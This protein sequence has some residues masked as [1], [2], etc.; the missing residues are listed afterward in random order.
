M[1]K[2]I[3]YY[4]P[5]IPQTEYF[6]YEFCG[7]KLSPMAERLFYRW[8]NTDK[9]YTVDNK[10]AWK[11]FV[12][13]IMEIDSSINLIQNC[14]EFDKLCDKMKSDCERRKE[15]KKIYNKEHKEEIA[16]QK[17]LD[18]ETFGYAIINGEKVALG[19]YLVEEMSPLIVRGDDKRMF[20]FKY[21]TEP[22]DITINCVGDNECKKALKEKGFNVVSKKDVD[23]IVSYKIKLSGGFPPITK[24]I[25]PSATFSGQIKNTEHKHEKAL[26]LLKHFKDF[27]EKIKHDLNSKN[28]K[29]REIALATWLVKTYAI[30]I[31]NEREEFQADTVGVT[32]LKTK[33]VSVYEKNGKKFIHLSFLAKDSVPYSKV[34]EIPTD[35]YSHFV[36]ILEG[37][38][39]SEQIFSISSNDVSKFIKSIYDEASPKTFRSAIGSAVL[40]E[41][42]NKVE[43]KKNMKDFEKKQ[44]FV[45]ANAE[46]AKYLNHKKGVTQKGEESFKNNMEKLN[47]RS[48]ELKE[49][50]KLEEEN[51]KTKKKYLTMKIK[52]C[53]E[54][55]LKTSE[56]KYRKQLEILKNKLERIRENVD[57]VNATKE[58]KNEG[59]NIALATSLNAYCSPAMV[60]SICKHIDLDPSKIYTKT[61]MTKFESFNDVS[62]NYWKNY[63][64]YIEEK[65]D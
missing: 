33:N 26:N 43:I 7:K 28:S 22:K 15:E 46:V 50:L 18:K 5:K 32:T 8:A 63:L 27:D 3:S 36:N 1:Y 11:N 57:K 55:G 47:E 31:G 49:K 53:K 54:K 13:A 58:L 24:S 20:C 16:K 14:I 40:C 48:K 29:D 59:K 12:N 19:G 10:Y 61:Q 64:G 52:Q 51:F 44:I 35:I 34:D 65:N 30:R 25:R 56:E 37:K 9:Q 21:P 17:E 23:W 41:E 62:S 4:G 45:K 2:S 60:F 6:G 42:I 38:K 39:P